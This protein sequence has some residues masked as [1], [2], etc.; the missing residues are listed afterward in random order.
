[1][2]ADTLADG[3]RGFL[4]SFLIE[5]GTITIVF[6]VRTSL[7]RNTEDEEMVQK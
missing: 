2:Q 6:K 1:M 4:P 7:D 5:T 3:Q